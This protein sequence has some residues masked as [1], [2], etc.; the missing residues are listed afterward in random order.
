M[1]LLHKAKPF[2]TSNV[3]VSRK[4]KKDDFD[5]AKDM[6]YV[7]ASYSSWSTFICIPKTSILRI[8]RPQNATAFF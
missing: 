5:V 4:K 2:T 7:V 8:R 1:P 3:F 6:K